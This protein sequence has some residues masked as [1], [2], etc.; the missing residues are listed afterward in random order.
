MITVNGG[1]SI[2]KL[3]DRLYRLND[4]ITAD[5]GRLITAKAGYITD[6]ASIPRFLWALVGSP[7]TGYYTRA[8]IIHDLLCERRCYDDGTPI[9][10][11][12]ADYIFFQIC[13]ADGERPIKS[14]VL[15]IGVRIGGL[16]G[17]KR[18]RKLYLHRICGLI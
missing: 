9:S 10:R 8:A 5:D 11:A 1:V 17:W 14:I 3:T 7:W 15:Y 13:I 12:D 16:S 6:G 2:T 18:K 4:P